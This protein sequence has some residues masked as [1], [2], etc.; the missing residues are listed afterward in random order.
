MGIAR[1]WNEEHEF[2]TV[3]LSMNTMSAPHK[4]MHN[5]ASSLN[6]ALPC[7]EFEAGELFVGS[8]DGLHRI[9]PDGPTG[10]ALMRPFCSHR[11]SFMLPFLGRVIGC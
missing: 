6:L 1:T 10:H 5:L 8:S 9:T 3:T 7:S 4:D 11:V 2:T